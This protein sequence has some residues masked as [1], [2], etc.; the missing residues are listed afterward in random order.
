[1]DREAELRQL[2][3]EAVALT[4]KQGAAIA[5]DDWDEMQVLLDERERCFDRAGAL[6]K[7][8]GHPANG[9]ELVDLLN[10]LKVLDEAN[11][12]VFRA[13]HHAVGYELRNLTSSR[14]A[15][16]GYKSALVGNATE[17][18]FIDQGR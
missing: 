1:M 15:L 5:R 6:L 7:Q 9:E 2:Y 10:Q 16:L 17:A 14:S 3:Q 8:G 12:R 18:H 4:R 11:Q 13:K